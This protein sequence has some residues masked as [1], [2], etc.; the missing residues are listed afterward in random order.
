MSNTV[1][2]DD[3]K[4]TFATIKAI[5]IFNFSTLCDWPKEDKTGNFV[6]GVYGETN[7]YSEL[8]KKY[9]SKT[10]GSQPIEIVQ[11]SS[12]SSIEKCH[13][14]FITS[15]NSSKVDDIS[16]D[17]KGESILIVSENSGALDDGSVINFV[18]EDNKQK[19]EIS[20]KNAGKRDIVIG[21]TLAQLA[22]KVIE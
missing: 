4:D 17:M 15:S 6:I 8:V 21:S 18:I 22:T 7:L 10:I 19:F 16:D 12:Q 11:Y 2:Q 3:G 1:V 9:S 5:F 13:I 14:L 20:K